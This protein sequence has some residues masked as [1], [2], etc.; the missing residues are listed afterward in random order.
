MYYCLGENNHTIGFVC[1]LSL[2]S[3]RNHCPNLFRLYRTILF[4]TSYDDRRGITSG[5]W[6][7]LLPIGI[8]TV[9]QK[10][11]KTSLWT[12]LGVP[13]APLRCYT[14][15][16]WDTTLVLL[17]RVPQEALYN[18][19]Y[20]QIRVEDLPRISWDNFKYFHI[21]ILYNIC[22]FLCLRPISGI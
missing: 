22:K 3:K 11:T 2:G 19:K 9:S 12:F 10:F 4:R 8:S 20:S 18:V 21:S 5:V 15:C 14:Q 6:E 16:L 13:T 1:N 17:T 7:L